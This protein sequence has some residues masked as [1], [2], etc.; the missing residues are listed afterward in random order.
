[1]EK[2]LCPN[3]EDPPGIVTEKI[4]LNWKHCPN[5]RLLW[6]CLGIS[7]TREGDI[8]G[9]VEVGKKEKQHRMLQ[10][11]PSQT[12]VQP[13]HKRGERAYFLFRQSLKEA[14]SL[15]RNTLLSD[16]SCSSGTRLSPCQEKQL[17]ISE[18]DPHLKLLVVK[19]ER[20]FNNCLDLNG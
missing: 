20:L 5:C 12:L 13:W 3:H 11:D 1:M 7:L 17:C 4:K 19:K 8:A 14:G 18:T 10:P 15:R 9:V 2:S 16:S 6:I